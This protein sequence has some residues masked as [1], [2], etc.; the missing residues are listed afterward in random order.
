[1]TA[2]MS[3]TVP[4]PNMAI[5]I[6]PMRPATEKRHAPGVRKISAYGRSGRGS[7]RSPAAAPTVLTISKHPQ[8]FPDLAGPLAGAAATRLPWLDGGM[9]AYDAF[10]LVSFGGPEGPDDV[11]PFLANVTRG[12]NIPPERLAGR[13][14]ALPGRRRGEPDQP[15]VP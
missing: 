6:R 8:R 3:S 11:M 13:G 15:A 1:M 2:E 7:L 12:R 4:S 10:L 14:R 5:G 9:P